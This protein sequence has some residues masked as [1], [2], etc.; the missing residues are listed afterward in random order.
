MKPYVCSECGERCWSL[1]EIA[2]SRPRCPDCWG[3][4]VD[5]SSPESGRVKHFI[6]RHEK[7][8]LMRK[9]EMGQHKPSTSNQEEVT[10]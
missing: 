9:K 1:T 2:H 8:D 5:K 10:S 3:R 4:F 7:R 6:D